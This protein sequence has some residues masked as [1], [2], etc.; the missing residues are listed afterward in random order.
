VV[1]FV[2][3]KH[4]GGATQRLWK[5]QRDALVAWIGRQG[6]RCVVMG[7]FNCDTGHRD[8]GPI[9]DVATIRTARSHGNRRIDWI[10]VKKADGVTSTAARALPNRGQSDHKPVLSAVTA[11]EEE[12]DG[13]LRGIDISVYQT[14]IDLAAVDADFVIV[15]AT[16]G[17]SYV[18][19]SFQTQYADAKAAGR[20][21]GI[22][23]FA[24]LN[25]AEVEAD[26]FLDT[27]GDR[28]GEAVLVLDWERAPLDDVDW[29]ARWLHRVL[30]RTGVQPMIYMSEAVANGAA[31]QNLGD[32][33]LWVAAYR[34]EDQH[35]NYDMGRAGRPPAVNDVA[36]PH[37][38]VM[39]QWSANGRLDGYSG[40]LDVNTCTLSVDEWKALAAADERHGG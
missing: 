40:P 3:S 10:V 25:A 35:P 28:V 19:P 9:K 38:W 33:P 26:F 32:C 16:E 18:S 23:H 14:G 21:L 34:T 29:C 24:A 15:K 6:E 1:H 12:R 17:R 4:L 20:L 30:D 8:T 22:Y 7:D 31:W 39:W 13:G 2:P 36:W 11:A 5:E 27:V 37:G